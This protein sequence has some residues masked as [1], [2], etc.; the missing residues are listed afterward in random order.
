[1]ARSQVI[2]SDNMDK[3]QKTKSKIINT[4]GKRK[5]AIARATLKP[6][7]GRITINSKPL[8]K[9]KPELAKLKI[10]EP[11]ILAGIA[12]DKIDITVTVNGGG[13]FGQ[14]DAA[15]QAISRG[16]IEWTKD[17]DLEKTIT[18]YDRTMIRYDPRRTEP[19]KPSRSKQGARRKKQLSKR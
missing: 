3:P 4:V 16:L 10:T 12:K 1:M 9:V 14:A 18:A 8:D 7:K 11:L 13:I 2:N 5:C 17:K 6:G 15:R 19:H